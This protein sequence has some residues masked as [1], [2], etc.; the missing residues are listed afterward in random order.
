MSTQSGTHTDKKSARRSELDRE[1]AM[2]LAATEY[3]RVADLLGRLTAEQWAAATDCPEWDVRAMAGHMLGMIQ[4]VASVPELMRQQ[5]AATRAAKRSGGLMIDALTAL[6]VEKNAALTAADV[7]GEIRTLA[8]RAV[9]NRRRAPA[10]IRNQTMQD[11]TDG[12]WT[13]GYLFDVILTRDPFM[14]RIDITRA[15]GVPMD[16]SAEHEGVIVADVV[17]EWAGRHGM[18][19]TLELTGPAG[20]RWQEGEGEHLTMDAFEFCRAVEGRAPSTGLL[21]TRVPF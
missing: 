6:Q 8:P 15:I 21:S 16:A 10:V 13:M 4:M 3:E 2:R 7:V 14:H 17:R 1:T 20:G 12:W 19:F 9:K 11:E 5:L 18:R